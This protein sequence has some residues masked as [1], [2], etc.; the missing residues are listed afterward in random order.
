MSPPLVLYVEDEENDV[1]FMQIGFETAGWH[2]AL[3]IA[4]NGLEAID[5]LAGAGS[6]GNRAKF[7]LPR[8]ILLDLNLPVRSGFEV[9]E[10]L[11][12]QPQFRALPVVVFTASNQECDKEKALR[13]GANEFITKPTDMSCLSELLGRIRQRWLIPS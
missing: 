9:L 11:R 5:Y 10:W 6:F 7:P 13:L 3:Q 2:H 1:F 4:K 12:Q 8:L